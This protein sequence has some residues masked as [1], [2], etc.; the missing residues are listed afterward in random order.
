MRKK[1]KKNFSGQTFNK[2]FRRICFSFSSFRSFSLD[3]RWFFFSLFFRS[4]L[5]IRFST[6]IAFAYAMGDE[7]RKN[8]VCAR[9]RG[10]RSL[11]TFA[12]FNAD[13]FFF[14]Y[15][16]LFLPFFCSF[17]DISFSLLFFFRYVSLP[18]PSSLGSLCVCVC[19]CVGGGSDLYAWSWPSHRAQTTR[20][21][22]P[23]RWYEPTSIRWIRASSPST[24]IYRQPCRWLLVRK[25]LPESQH[26]PDQQPYC[27]ASFTI[28]ARARWAFPIYIF[29]IHI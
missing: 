6:F 8:R 28:L 12:W 21:P 20:R 17:H 26:S 16:A 13:F 22:L 25:I 10:T 27:H 3:I 1:N 19:V 4:P 18:S 15:L 5:A 11:S 24:L 14:R 2:P 7:R 9:E 29:Y 23:R